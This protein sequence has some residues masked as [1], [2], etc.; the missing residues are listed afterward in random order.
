MTEWTRYGQEFEEM[1]FISKGG[2]GNVF[3]ARHRLDG[4]LYAVKKVVVPSR[5]VRN[6]MRYLEEVKTL[7]ALNHP[8]IVPYKGAWIEPTIL[9]TFVQNLSS[10]SPSDKCGLHISEKL[11]DTGSRK[12]RRNG[13]KSFSPCSGFKKNND[14]KGGVFPGQGNARPQ[15][16]NLSISTTNTE[17][18]ISKN[19][20]DADISDKSYSSIVSFRGDDESSDL[21]KKRSDV[22][23]AYESNSNEE[24]E[25]SESLDESIAEQQICR[26]NMKMVS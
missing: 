18:R 26:Y 14:K 7:A 16:L 20:I 24:S 10:P 1:G 17:L 6:I 5:R 25:E 12:S 22:S 19:E 11:S 3:K 21:L 8:N 13:R 4:T 9:S 23:P 15:I 2:F